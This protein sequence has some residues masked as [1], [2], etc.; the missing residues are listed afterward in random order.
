MVP[1]WQECTPEEDTSVERRREDIQTKWNGDFE[2]AQNETGAVQAIASLDVGAEGYAVIS[3][4]SVV[5]CSMSTMSASSSSADSGIAR[6][7]D[8][9]NLF[10]ADSMF[11]NAAVYDADTDAKESCLLAISETGQPGSGAPQLPE[12]GKESR[13]QRVIFLYATR[14]ERWPCCFIT[15]YIVILGVLIGA[16]WRPL[17]VDSDFSSFIRADGNAM[18]QRDAYEQALEILKKQQSR[19]LQAI[20]GDQLPD[21]RKHPEQESTAAM[22]VSDST[23]DAAMEEQLGLQPLSLHDFGAVSEEDARWLQE[24][25]DTGGERLLQSSGRFLQFKLPVVV[26]VKQLTFSYLP[27]HGNAFDHHLLSGMKDF[28]NGLRS[29]SGWKSTCSEG[30]DVDHQILCNPGESF[31]AYTYP[32]KLTTAGTNAT[33]TRY[34]L[35]FDANGADMLQLPAALTYL[36]ESGN[37]EHSLLRFFPKDYVAPAVGTDLADLPPPSAL[38]T[39]YTFYL[40]WEFANTLLRN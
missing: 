12:D 10:T 40:L 21:T 8:R 32:T 2:S 30:V 13:L 17:E 20:P 1:P 33:S 9:H 14:L 37:P 22:F 4:A 23:L 18:R 26:V 28:E 27:D 24:V 11:V 38:K 16:A 6:P 39:K 25:Q 15:L 34:M 5:E 31:A 3:D 7:R 36:Q 35:K 29:L 19:R